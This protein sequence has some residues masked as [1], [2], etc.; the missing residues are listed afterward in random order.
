MLK[1]PL[2]SVL[3]YSLRKTQGSNSVLKNL[4]YYERIERIYFAESSGLTLSILVGYSHTSTYMKVCKTP[5]EHKSQIKQI[6]K[7]HC[8]ESHYKQ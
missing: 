7:Q 6:N 3:K 4:I 8:K 5:K 2:T 1:S